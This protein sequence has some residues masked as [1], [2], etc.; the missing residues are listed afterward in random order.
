MAKEKRPGA[1]KEHAVI[2]PRSKVPRPPAVPTGRY[3]YCPA[4]NHAHEPRLL[5]LLR[6]QKAVFFRCACG[7]NGFMSRLWT[8]SQGY[9][10]DQAR[11]L[12]KK[13]GVIVCGI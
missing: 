6:G 1:P 7:T 11:D 3:V 12:A 4:S 13:S 5:P 8:D 2:E 10:F 9:T